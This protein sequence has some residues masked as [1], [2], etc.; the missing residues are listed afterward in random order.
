M[1]H[2]SERP[3]ELCFPMKDNR[4]QSRIVAAE[5]AGVRCV[6]SFYGDHGLIR[7]R[8]PTDIAPLLYPERVFARFREVKQLVEN[9]L[10][11]KPFTRLHRTNR[12]RFEHSDRFVSELVLFGTEPAPQLRL[13]R[14]TGVARLHS[15]RAA[16]PIPAEMGQTVVIR[17]GQM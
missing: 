17:W 13:R 14:P 15:R 7:A 4:F 5:R 16:K 6:C 9:N 10:L 12:R 2:V 8:C 3:V 1:S 11:R